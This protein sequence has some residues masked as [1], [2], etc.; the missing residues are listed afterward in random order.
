MERLALP[1]GKL[2]EIRM[3]QGI[4]LVAQFER[5]AK[6]RT[7]RQ[8]CGIS[9]SIR[10][11]RSNSHCSEGSRSSPDLV[12]NTV[13]A[14]EWVDRSYSRIIGQIEIDIADRHAPMKDCVGHQSCLRRN[15]CSYA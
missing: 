2:H 9:W 7:R 1:V 8:R 6:R 4:V 14:R 11:G 5:S 3:H 10:R 15:G 13:I 12:T